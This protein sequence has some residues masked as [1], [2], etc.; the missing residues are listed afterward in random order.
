MW[1]M[2]KFPMS[3]SVRVC[4]CVCVFVC[5]CV[6]VCVCMGVCVSLCV[7]LCVSVKH[8]QTWTYSDNPLSDRGQ[9]SS[10]D[11]P[12]S[13]DTCKRL[14]I[15][16]LTFAYRGMSKITCTGY[17]PR[18]A[19]LHTKCLKMPVVRLTHTSSFSES[20]IVVHNYGRSHACVCVC[21]CVWMG[22]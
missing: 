16:Y 21:V 15:A 17:G 4:V 10:V 14:Q 12:R 2:Q 8:R 22:V 6:C 7:C 9:H 1:C 5:V 19:S 18:S 13:V 3:V 20:N 11:G